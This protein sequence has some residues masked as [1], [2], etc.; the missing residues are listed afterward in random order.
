M[1]K[2]TFDLDEETVAA[3]EEL[4]QDEG[5]KAAAVRQAIV[6]LHRRRQRLRD[7]EKLAEGIE[8]TAEELAD[9]EAWAKQV[10]A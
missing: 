10:L 1:T 3:L 8:Y 6:T 4:A 9:A 7:A 5:S 2:H